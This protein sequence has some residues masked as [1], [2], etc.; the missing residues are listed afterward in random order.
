MAKLTIE[1]DVKELPD[2][3][4]GTLMIHKD[5]P[6]FI[7]MATSIVVGDEFA[8]VALPDGAYGEQ[9]VIDEY[10]VFQGTLKLE[11]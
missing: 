9:W 4:P 10:S 7:V 5:Q 8:G 11:Q 2:V 3:V 6:P 1:S